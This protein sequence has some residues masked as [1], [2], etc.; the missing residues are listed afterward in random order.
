M[1][2]EIRVDN[3]EGGRICFKKQKADFELHNVSMKMQYRIFP[4][5][6]LQA[7]CRNYR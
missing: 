3:S 5:K 1:H 2:F 6:Y 4:D 7:V